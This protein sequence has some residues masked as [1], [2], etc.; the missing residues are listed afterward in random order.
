MQPTTRYRWLGFPLGMYLL[1]PGGEVN[2]LRAED[3]PKPGG[4]F[5]R[6]R[7]VTRGHGLHLGLP[8]FREICDGRPWSLHLMSSGRYIQGRFLFDLAPRR[9]AGAKYSH[10]SHNSV[11]WQSVP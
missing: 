8:G 5:Q 4:D 1:G 7:R 3:A 11:F 9:P 10:H 2:C 6:D